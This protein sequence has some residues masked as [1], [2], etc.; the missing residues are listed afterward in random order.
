M[1]Q[2]VLHRHWPVAAVIA[3]GVAAAPLLAHHQWETYAW[4]SDGT[5]LVTPALVDNTDNRWNGHVSQAVADWNASQYIDSGIEYGNNSSCAMV[6]GTIQV[7]NDDYGSNG[8][9]GLATIA[10]SSGTIVAGSTKLNDNFFERERYN[11]PTMRQLVTCQ[12]IG[13]DYGLGHQNEDFSTDLTTSCMEYTSQPEGNE[14]PDAHDYD[15]LARMYGSGSGG[16]D[17]GDGGGKGNGNG[18]GGGDGGGK[19]DGK[20]GGKAKNKVG[21][22]VRVALPAT[23]NTPTSWGR[24]TAFLPNGKPFR[25]VRESG[26]YKFVTH[27]T[28]AP[29]SHEGGDHDH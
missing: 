21:N 18:K 19:P 6:T 20:G 9:L 8:W 17:A 5:N 14:S 24:P 26:R 23:G 1:K 29:E 13:H 22:K 28:W 10:L 11:N 3:A 25:F 2:T 12:E 7:C 27:V 15:E 16:G 4:A